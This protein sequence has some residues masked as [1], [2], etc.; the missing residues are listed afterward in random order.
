LWGLSS[1]RFYPFP[2]EFI[3]FWD[4]AV[5]RGDSRVDKAGVNELL[6]MEE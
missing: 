1:P 2:P 6:V 4:C 5:E 3:F